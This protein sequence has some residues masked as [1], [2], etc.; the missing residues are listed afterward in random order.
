[1]ST[2]NTGV[3]LSGHVPPAEVAQAVWS[4]PG[5]L[6]GDLRGAEA[7]RAGQGERGGLRYTL[8][9]LRL[10]E[11]GGL[12]TLDRA[13]VP[14]EDDL[15][16]HVG[17][18]LSRDRAVVFLH[19]DEERGA[20]GYARFEGGRLVA[21][22]VVDGR[23]YQPVARD[24]GG[25]RPL[26]V[27]DEE[28]WIWA[29]ISDALEEGAAPVLGPGVRTDDDLAAIIAATPLSTLV[30]PTGRAWHPATTASAAPP[31]SGRLRGLLRRLQG[32]SG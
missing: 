32:E 22:R 30:P 24:L 28:A 11:V 17:R 20:G 7:P 1:M 25:E 9:A 21:R 12:L 27:A 14:P 18:Q 16:I 10:F 4:W 29:D 3:F 31:R 23:D 19:F 26:P 13:E 6:E 2:R 15:E 5:F 8:L